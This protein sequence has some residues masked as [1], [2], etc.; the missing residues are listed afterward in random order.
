MEEANFRILIADRIAQEGIELLRSQLPEAHIDIQ[1]G[2]K[3]EQLRASI[4][5]YTA[6]I[7]RSE[8]QVT[9]EI[10]A[11]ARRLKI[12][13]R[14]GV[15]VDNIDIEAA[16]RQGIMVV[17][18]PTGNIVAAAEHTI[19]MLM[20]LARHVPAANSSMK[21]GKWEKSRFLGV[22]VRNKILGIRRPGE[23]GQRGSATR[24]GAGNAGYRL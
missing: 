17:N 4:G 6:L 9:G 21:A 5:N 22:E 2:L 7:V 3:P 16:T 13:G 11:A 10:L 15:G 1:L 12:V 23:S 24:P 20:A 19:A 8:T 14:A 18:S